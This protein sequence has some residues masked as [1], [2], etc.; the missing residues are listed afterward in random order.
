MAVAAAGRLATTVLQ[1]SPWGRVPASLNLFRLGVVGGRGGTFEQV[2]ASLVAQTAAEFVQGHAGSPNKGHVNAA[3]GLA[4]SHVGRCIR[5]GGAV[6]IPRWAEKCREATVLDLFELPAGGGDALAEGL[7]RCNAALVLHETARTGELDELERDVLPVLADFKVPCVLYALAPLDAVQAGSVGLHTAVARWRARHS[8]LLRDEVGN[9]YA[10]DL[11]CAGVWGGAFPAVHTAQ[12]AALY[13]RHKLV[14][15]HTRAPTKGFEAAIA[16]T[17]GAF[18]QGG[19]SAWGPAQWR[20]FIG[21]AYDRAPTGEEEELFLRLCAA[22]CGP[23]AAAAAG[24]PE[25]AQQLTCDVFGSWL[26]NLVLLGKTPVVWHFLRSCGGYNG[27]LEVVSR[28]GAG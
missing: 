7:A 4:R 2:A 23:G 24:P 5:N 1:A 12:M 14:A 8:D 6:G 17:F 20:V 15:R 25:G 16:R 27:H 9:V 3:M 21:T 22:S 13:P 11:M 26:T 18:A 19:E 28:A 10:A